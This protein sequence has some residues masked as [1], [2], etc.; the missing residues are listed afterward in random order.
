LPYQQAPE[1]TL[2]AEA[3]HSMKDKKK[4]KDQLVTE[5][6]ELRRE[7]A[8]LETSERHRK[9]ADKPANAQHDL[10]L[11][12]NATVELDEVL[13]KARD[14]LEVR[15]HERT[16]ELQKTNE[17]LLA[18]ISEYQQVE[19]ALQLERKQLLSIFDSI[20]EIIYV[21]DPKT[22]KILYVNRALRNTF[23]K[24]LVGGICYREFQG[25]NSP[26]KFCTNEIILKKKYKPY[27]WDYHNPILNKDYAIVDRIIKW[28]DGRDVRFELAI[29]ITDR[30]RAEEALRESQARL[31][32]IFDGAVDAIFTKDLQGKYVAINKTCRKLFGLPEEKII[33]KTDFDLFPAE[34]ARHIR[35]TDK[36]ILRG[37][38]VT[39]EDTKPLGGKTYTFHITKVPLYDDQ[40]KIF[41]LCGIARDV[42][43]HKRANK[44]LL[45]SRRKIKRLHGTAGELEACQS[46]HEV[47]QL[48]VE[49]AE[50]ILVLTM[51]SL[52][53]VEGKK[54]VVKATTSELPVGASTETDLDET[55]LAAK[56]YHTGKTIVFGKLAEVPEARPTREDFRSG[57]SA[58]IG[59][60]GVF[61]AVSTEP[62][63]FSD[64]D[65]ELLELLL[66]HA[67]EAVRRIRLR[68]ELRE[69][70]TR[71]PLTGVYNRRYFSETIERE[72]R[73]SR[74]YQHP[75]GF[76]MI[77]VDRF[78]EINDTHGHQTGDRVL[79]E[80]AN[81]L[82]K[83]V[84]I[85]EMVV[86]FGGDEFLIVMPEM[87]KDIDAVKQR[88]I[89]ALARWNETSELFDFPVTFSSGGARWNPDGLESVEHVL[90]RAD[91]LMYADKKRQI[92]VKHSG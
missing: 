7:I 6:A 87:E 53:I 43:E 33:G 51:C 21:A 63:A 28:P 11:A 74:R 84:R 35:K 27:Q 47:Y 81:F 77:D 88:L 71:D 70:A 19:E 79:Q 82:R 67:A 23:Q 16:V 49:A 52:D 25:L 55:S 4:T 56:T 65:V 80:V 39:E 22:Y 38:I 73:R 50:K 37:E 2:P 59:D 92:A 32:A 44:K 3:V 9:L 86:R 40:G 5:L 83:S 8:K 61:Q 85:T 60:I 14:E 12:L 34:N 31:K 90:A 20:D 24:K 15:V 17:A 78:K 30:K 36:K 46:E 1:K 72:L 91:R 69:Q 18:E 75:I 57:I 45:E 58:P 29:D 41:G 54:L 68:N 64:E 26:C 10:A 89:E 76:L 48:T 42:T 13:R 66:G 62:D